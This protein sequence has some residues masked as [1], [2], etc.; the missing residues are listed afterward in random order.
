M[1]NRPVSVVLGFL[2]VSLFISPDSKMCFSLITCS[3]VSRSVCVSV[4]FFINL[5]VLEQ[6]M[7]AKK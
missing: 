7:A 6:Q 2:E 5:L 1:L 3:V 4:L